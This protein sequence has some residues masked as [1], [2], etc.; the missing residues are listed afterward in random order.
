MGVGDELEGRIKVSK[1]EDNIRELDV[2]LSYQVWD[3][4]STEQYYRIS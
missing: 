3:G 2:V 1:A 4:P